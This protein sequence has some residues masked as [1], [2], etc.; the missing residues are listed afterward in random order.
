[1]IHF[2]LDSFFDDSDFHAAD[3]FFILFSADIGH[4]FV[5]SSF[6]HDRFSLLSHAI[7]AYTLSKLLLYFIDISPAVSSI[8]TLRP[9]S[10]AEID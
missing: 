5:L 2:Q 3:I 1:M 8:H 9:D 10:I 4:I 7:I 6:F